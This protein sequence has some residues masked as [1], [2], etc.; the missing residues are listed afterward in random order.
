MRLFSLS[1][2]LIIQFPAFGNI[3]PQNPPNSQPLPPLS[4]WDATVLGL[5][6]GITEFLPISSTGHLIIANQ[7]LNLNSANF[8]NTTPN[9]TT[10]H[11]TIKNAIDSY[12]IVI[13]GGT[14]LT[15]IFL[16]WNRITAILLGLIGRNPAG[17]KLARNILLAFLPAAI[18][19]LLLGKWIEKYLFNPLTVMI[20]LI[21]GA[22]L[23]LQTEKWRKSKTQETQNE[24]NNFDLND[25]SIK[26]ALGIGSLQCIAMWPG[27]SRSMITIVGGYFAGLSPSKAA[28][29]SF[30]LGLLTLTAAGSYKLLSD[31]PDMIKI[32]SLG[33]AILGCSVAFITGALAVKWLI[34]YLNKYGLSL[35][36]WYRLA[37]A[38][39]IFFVNYII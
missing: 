12:T 30:L 15:I 8:D 21:G 17:I 19:G 4:Y 2:F 32:L 28:E 34:R 33:P 31:G 10:H 29:F 5:I 9:P 6:Q 37:L 36:A 1:L 38:L 23:I 20:A 13:Q 25:L 39:G 24:E 14:I 22:I 18:L 7:A 26:Q 16:Y 27:I 35:F 3:H 11:Y